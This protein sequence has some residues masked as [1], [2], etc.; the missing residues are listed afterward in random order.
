MNIESKVKIKIDKK[1][2]LAG[3]ASSREYY[4]VISGGHSY[5]LS[6]DKGEF[7][8]NKDFYK[9]TQFF[10]GFVLTP[11][12]V[13]VTEDKEIIIQEDVGDINIGQMLFKN[14]EIYNKLMNIIVE[15]IK[16]YQTIKKEE[17]KKVSDYEF[18]R[19]KLE[20]EF[21]LATKFFATNFLKI[22]PSDD[23]FNKVKEFFVKYFLDNMNVVCHRDYHSRN[24]MYHDGKII[25]IDYQDARLGPETY[26]L[27]S[28]MEDAYFRHDESRKKEI[29]TKFLR[30]K[31]LSERD[32]NIVASQR[33]YKALG[34]F[35][36]LKFEKNKTQ[37]EKNISNAFENLR[38]CASQVPELRDWISELSEGYYAN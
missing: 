21:D 1:I 27:A 18:D 29:I 35:S 33:L 20:F 2:K 16:K 30:E 8:Q 25:H 12:I 9:T 24:L 6:L 5:I 38:A 10:K 36:Y 26:D 32:Y 15:D 19:K 23:L 14:D 34:S 22:A 13:E 7:Q 37:Y 31:N 4:R 28:F 17:F 3:D 11:T